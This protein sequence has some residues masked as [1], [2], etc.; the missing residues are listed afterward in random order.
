MPRKAVPLKER[1]EKHFIPEPNSGCWLWLSATIAGGPKNNPALYGVIGN[2]RGLVPKMLMAHR[3]SY[4]VYKGEI[5]EGHDIDHECRNTLCVNPDHLQPLTRKRHIKLTYEHARQGKC[6]RGHLMTEKN[7][8]I[9]KTGQ[10][11]CRR[12]HADREAKNRANKSKRFMC[13]EVLN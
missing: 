11:H 5:P 6:K 13:R 9:E 10:A 2:D 12:C 1:F 7:S 8:W 3:A 4:Q